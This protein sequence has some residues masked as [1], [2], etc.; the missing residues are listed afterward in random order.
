MR[1]R[2]APRGDDPGVRRAASPRIRAACCSPPNRR[3]A[4]SCC[5]TCCGRSASSRA[6]SP[7]GRNSS[8]GDARVA[9]TVAPLASGV[10][11]ADPPLTIYAE[12]QL[13]GE[14]ARQERRRR[15]S[16][17][18][19]A[20]I[21]QQLADLR[22]GAPVVHEDYG[23]GRYLGLTTMDAG[24]MPAEFLVLEYADGDKLYVPVQALERIS[25]YTGAP[26]ETA[27]LHK[28]GGDQWSK[29]RAKAAAQHPRRGGRTARRLLAP[30]RP[31][32]PRFR[33]RR[34]AAARVRGRLPVR[35]N[36]RPGGRDRSRCSTTCARRGRWTASSAATSASARPRSRCAPRSSPC[37]AASRWRC[38]CRPPCSPSSTTRRSPTAS[39][40]GRSRSSCCRASAATR[41][42]KGALAGLADGQGG[43]RHRHAP[44]AAGRRALQGPRAADHRRGAPLRRARQGAAQGAAR[45]GRRADADRDADPAHAQ[46]GAR[47]PARPVADHHAAGRAPV[48]QDL[49][50]GVERARDPRGLPARAA[51]RRPGVLRAQHHR[52]H[53][54]HVAAARRAGARGAHRHRPRPDARARPRAGDARL[55]PPARQPAAVHDHHRERHRRAD[56]E[57]HHHRPRRPLRPRAA[58]PA[59]RPR[60]P[61]APP[62]LRLP[63]HAAA[64]TR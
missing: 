11:L 2:R 50:V 37:R 58:A 47:R 62:G 18:D 6:R 27:P 26:A 48:D 15:R 54:G 4:A 57:H 63:D 53:R 41:R 14:R 32:G 21:I 64:R 35:G 5:S 40:T 9:V 49:R 61:L 55:L 59:A 10:A 29:A 13:F 44:A 34:A 51:P 3:A 33:R 23:V 36:R 39:P 12:E 22:P 20:R 24:G 52:D 28:L 16:D 42:R 46:H 43:H 7:A 19:P 45:R 31:P 8:T 17:R 1:A 30:R 56:R 25:R 60:R 38:W